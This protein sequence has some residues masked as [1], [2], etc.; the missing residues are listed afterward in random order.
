[1][2]C[3]RYDSYLKVN[4]E[5]ICF[6]DTKHNYHPSEDSPGGTAKFVANAHLGTHRNLDFDGPIISLGHH[7]G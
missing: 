5:E 2:L 4:R 7:T 6:Y 3:V 1:M